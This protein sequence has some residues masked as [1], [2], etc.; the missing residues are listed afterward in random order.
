LTSRGMRLT[1]NFTVRATPRTATFRG[2]ARVHLC[3]LQGPVLARETPGY[4]VR[5]AGEQDIIACNTLAERVHGHHRS[6]ELRGAVSQGTAA[7]V[8]RAGRITCYATQIAFFGHA[9]TET[10]DDIKALISASK[11]FEASAG[12]DER[13]DF[14]RD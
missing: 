7:V 5:P 2:E 1:R 11:E 3:C 6:A 13:R 14:R 12:R 10:T 8:E 4:R 9:C